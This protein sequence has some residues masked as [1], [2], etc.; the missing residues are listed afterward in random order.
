MISR[1]KASVNNNNVSIFYRALRHGSGQAPAEYR[2]IEKAFCR[3]A[4]GIISFSGVN[5]CQSNRIMKE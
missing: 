3:P 1:N 5:P 4:R 2:I